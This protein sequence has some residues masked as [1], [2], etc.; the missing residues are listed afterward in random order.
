MKKTLLGQ[1]YVKRIF[2]ITGNKGSY[3]NVESKSA[4]VG[5]TDDGNGRF[6]I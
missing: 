3:C 6:W 4:L 5:K 1:N 2:N